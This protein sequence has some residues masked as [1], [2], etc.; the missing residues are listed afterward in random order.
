MRR[1]DPIRELARERG[2]DE[3]RL[4]EYADAATLD[5]ALNGDYL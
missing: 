3:E 1:N 2:I 4:R 5:A